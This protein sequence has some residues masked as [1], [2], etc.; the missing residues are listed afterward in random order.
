MADQLNKIAKLCFSCVVSGAYG[1]KDKLRRDN[2]LS[3][4]CTKSSVF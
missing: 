2:R 3:P 1:V 4:P